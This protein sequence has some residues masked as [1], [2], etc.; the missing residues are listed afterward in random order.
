MWRS[1]RVRHKGGVVHEF[2]II[3]AGPFDI[4]TARDF[5]GGF[6]PGMGASLDEPDPTALLVVFPVEDWLSSAAVE[7]RQDVDGAVVG[8]VFGTDDVD[9][10]R[11]QALRCV[12]L[13]H[14]GSGW[15]E[16][17]A[18]DPVIGA[19]QERYGMLR[20]V[21]F[22]SAWEA[23]TSFVIGHRISMRQGAVV[24]QRLAAAVGDAIELPDGRT[25]HAFPRP[26]TLLSVDDI[27]GISAEKVRR[28]HGLARAALDG[29]LDTQMLRALPEVDALARLEALPGIGPWTA[30]AVLMRGCG[31]V[32]TLP[33]GD[34]TTRRA[35]GT[36]YGLGDEVTDEQW[37][38]IAEAWRPYR[39]WATVLLHMA[40][41]REDSVTP[42][43]RQAR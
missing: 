34:V 14:D 1:E 23:A 21:C 24:K 6:A 29:A 16:V 32:D 40:A 12:S 26:A 7:L 30:S 25:L 19:L 37:L 2:R 31:T 28:L 36:S 15:P 41:R 3:P 33:M 4:A 11:T 10:A 38:T 18:R 39:M 13:D 17:G 9:G 20:P 27:P 35:V 42:S 43:Y 5:A 8:R 22:L